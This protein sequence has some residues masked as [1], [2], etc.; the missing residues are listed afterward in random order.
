MI[1][2]NEN[3]FDFFGIAEEAI[4]SLYAKTG[5]ILYTPEMY[6]PIPKK[7]VPEIGLSGMGTEVITASKGSDKWVD[8]VLWISIIVLVIVIIYAIWDLTKPEPIIQNLAL[9]KRK[10]EELDPS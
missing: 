10:N 4:R 5:K 8:I 3:F 2:E 7:T 9:P 1:V 6:L